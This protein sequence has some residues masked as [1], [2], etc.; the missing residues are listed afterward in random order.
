MR[1]GESRELKALARDR[2]RRRVEADLEF[3]WRIAEGAGTLDNPRDQAA[4]FCAGAEPGLTRVG[5]TVR[6]R[7][8]VCEAEALVTVTHELLPQI[9][10]AAVETQGL[11]GYTFER[12]AGES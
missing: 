9:G 8:V 5:V 7:D 6:Q 1:V 3:E 10:N 2:A 11:P 4:R 12:A